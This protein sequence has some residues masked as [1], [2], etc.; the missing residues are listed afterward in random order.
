MF[1]NNIVKQIIEAQKKGRVILTDAGYIEF[2]KLI[3]EEYHEEQIVEN[4]G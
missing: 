1:K 4:A 2:L 3:N